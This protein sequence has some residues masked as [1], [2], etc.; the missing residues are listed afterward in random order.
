METEHG[1]DLFNVTRE[2]VAQKWLVL[3]GPDELSL[4]KEEFES[5]RNKNLTNR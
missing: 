5:R 4:P 2:D 3:F 1:V